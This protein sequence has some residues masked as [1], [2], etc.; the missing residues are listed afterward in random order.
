MP[1]LPLRLFRRWRGFTLIELLVVIA[2]IAILIGLLLPAVQKVREA[3]NRAQCQNNLKQLSLA[4]QNCVDTHHGIIP[5]SIGNYPIQNPSPNNGDGGLYFHLFPYIEQQNIY[6]ASYNATG[7]NT[8]RN[9]GLPCYSSWSADA[10]ANPKVLMCPSDPTM[11]PNGKDSWSGDNL[12]SYGY[13]GQVFT[14]AYPNGWGSQKMYPAYITDGTSQTIFF[15]DKLAVA[16]QT[17]PWNFDSGRNLWADWGPSINSVE[18][19][20]PSAQPSAI[21]NGAFNPSL[22]PTTLFWIIGQNGH[23]MGG[24]DNGAYSLNLSGDAS[25]PHVG[26]INVAMG[27]GSAH[28]EGQG[29]SP[30]TWWYALTPNFGDI[31]GPDW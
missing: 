26:G 7:P 10:F 6:N 27:D 5:P 3:A 30:G 28:F 18:C 14:L 21:Y 25:S 4:V 1:T 20:C 12:T 13:N 24:P 8:G 16:I 11:P 15:T 31:L 29:V 22:I 17:S 9:G 23:N 2:I 19:N